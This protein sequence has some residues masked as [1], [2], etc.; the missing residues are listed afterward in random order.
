ME[1]HMKTP[2]QRV[3]AA[4]VSFGAIIVASSAHAEGPTRLECE[5]NAKAASAAADAAIM[6]KH[7][8]DKASAGV[9][10]GSGCGALI[11]LTGWFDFGTGAAICAVATAAA[12]V[13]TPAEANAEA[14]KEAYGRI[15]DPRC[16]AP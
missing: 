4:I 2:I 8:L 6:S 12:V 10:V 11:F 9:V 7:D 16:V 15:R 13:S 1:A 5:I 14:A 3:I